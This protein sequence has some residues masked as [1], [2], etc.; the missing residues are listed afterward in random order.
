MIAVATFATLV[1][2]W[3]WLHRR[4]RRNDWGF[5]GFTPSWYRERSRRFVLTM[6]EMAES[7]L[8]IAEAM[9]TVT[10]TFNALAAATRDAK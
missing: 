4:S 10:R 1:A 9:R 2:Y 6:R 3:A 5:V 8:K 7:Q